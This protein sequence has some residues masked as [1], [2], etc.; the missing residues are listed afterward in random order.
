[1]R[2]RQL[3]KK[4]APLILEWMK[5]P[6]INC[7]FR[8]NSETITIE[9]IIDFIEKAMNSQSDRHYA[10]VDDDDT[11]LGTVSLKKIDRVNNNAEYA[12]SLRKSVIG[13]GAALFATSELI[14]IAFNKLELHKVYL[15]V[16]S[17]N[18]RAIMF[19]EKMGF[20]FEGE[21]VDHLLIRNQYRNL[22]WYAIVR[23]L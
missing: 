20:V 9:S 16:L 19:Y 18:M 12:I 6:E 11:Y 4:D 8:F 3:H 1:M 5:D 10:L 21:F 17:D 14:K 7:F 13:T 22:K 23:Q 15:N 2:L